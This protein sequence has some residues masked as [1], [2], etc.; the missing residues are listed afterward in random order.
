MFVGFN[1]SILRTPRRAWIWQMADH[2]GLRRPSLNDG[3]YGA[4][5]MDKLIIC[6]QLIL[7]ESKIQ[8]TEHVR[9][10]EPAPLSRK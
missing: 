3:T 1:A 8:P 5:E 2:I 7:K 10:E 9:P 6:W 4:A